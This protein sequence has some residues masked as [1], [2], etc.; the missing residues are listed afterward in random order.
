MQQY[1]YDDFTPITAPAR[2]TEMD[3]FIA[4]C[5]EDDAGDEAQ[6]ADE[7]ARRAEWVYER[8]MDE[9]QAWMQAQIAR[10]DRR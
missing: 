1:P 8:A 3:A 7:A 9:R 2:L 5:V 4:A 6:R 10:Q